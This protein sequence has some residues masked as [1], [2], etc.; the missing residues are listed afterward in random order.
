MSNRPPSVS[1][2]RFV[3]PVPAQVYTHQTML[4]PD[5]QA[6]VPSSELDGTGYDM[7][8][9]VSND[10]A[11]TAESLASD[12]S[13]FGENES[14]HYYRYD[15]DG[16]DT[17]D[18]DGQEETM[19]GSSSQFGVQSLS[20]TMTA[21]PASRVVNHTLKR[22]EDIL[23]SDMNSTMREK[24]QDMQNEEDSDTDDEQ[25]IKLELPVRE[26]FTI[27]GFHIDSKTLFCFFLT[28]CSVVLVTQSYLPANPTS[29]VHSQEYEQFLKS[30]LPS[31][32]TATPSSSISSSIAPVNT[33]PVTDGSRFI[34]ALSFSSMTKSPFSLL[35]KGSS[36]EKKK[37]ATKSQSAKAVSSAKDIV[38]DL[39]QELKPQAPKPSNSLVKGNPSIAS[40][41]AF[42]YPNSGII[43]PYVS[44]PRPNLSGRLGPFDEITDNQQVFNLTYDLATNEYNLT[45]TRPYRGSLA[46]VITRDSKFVTRGHM[47]NATAPIEWVPSG[48][49]LSGHSVYNVTV[50]VPGEG[51][52]RRTAVHFH[53]ESSNLFAVALRLT[54]ALTTYVEPYVEPLQNSIHANSEK[55][56]KLMSSVDIKEAV[57]QAQGSAFVLVNN[58][59][60]R[61]STTFNKVIQRNAGIGNTLSRVQGKGVHNLVIMSGKTKKAV[62]HAQKK[63]KAIAKKMNKKR[64]ARL[65]RRAGRKCRNAEKKF[66][67]P[68]WMEQIL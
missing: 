56:E 46:I 41:R 18:V 5:S 55:I 66:T 47:Q 53:G 37:E 23:N 64:L 21:T 22:A 4:R 15:N 49:R 65:H 61:V 20:S 62:A 43:I 12:G 8:S 25:E 28:F 29:S 35:T 40:S 24:H 60:N 33:D 11:M 14:V 16:G 63:V 50:V 48:I 2:P 31:L 57:V 58:L 26:P 34:D 45:S 27:L 17:T 3:Y 44:G 67:K 59:Q 1:P 19:P 13:E 39:P 36:S 54:S 6:S 42:I 7:L 52:F 51:K 32:A 10:D 9:D 30:N 38:E 68:R